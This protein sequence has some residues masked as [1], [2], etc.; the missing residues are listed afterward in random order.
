[1]SVSALLLLCVFGLIHTQILSAGEECVPDQFLCFPG[2]PGSFKI[3]RFSSGREGYRATCCTIW[4]LFSYCFHWFCLPAGWCLCWMFACL[5]AVG[6]SLCG[7][8]MFV[9]TYMVWRKCILRRGIILSASGQYS[10]ENNGDRML[11][12]ANMKTL[13]KKDAKLVCFTVPWPQQQTDD[14]YY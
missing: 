10:G 6:C 2:L 7:S 9:F 8:Y 1:M 3:S 4:L 13:L 5:T 11:L 14:V 12:F